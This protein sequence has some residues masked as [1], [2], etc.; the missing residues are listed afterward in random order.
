[1]NQN[2]MS[3]LNTT[4]AVM[5]V[6]NDKVEGNPLVT[7]SLDQSGQPKTDLNG[8]ELGSLRLEQVSRTINGSFVNSRK[9]VAFLTGTM[10]EL[11][12]IVKSNK[13]VN[14]SQV[15]GKII[16]IESLQPMW[17]NQTPKMNP[18]T[19][20]EIGVTVNGTFYPVYM[21]QRY[22]EDMNAQDKLIRTAEDVNDWVAN[23]RAL[24]TVS[25]APE[26]A[27]IPQA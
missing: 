7:P 20:E 1:M 15:P 18:Q 23:Q 27:G 19:A 14:G 24:T 4:S 11:L 16:Q 26:T 5:L 9:R 3:F 13:L 25:S 21:Q 12:N 17:K 10:D 8:N 6:A 2:I 22:T